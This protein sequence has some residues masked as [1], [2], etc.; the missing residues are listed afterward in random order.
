[1]PY[2][3]SISLEETMAKAND[4]VG[5]PILT[6]DHEIYSPPLPLAVRWFGRVGRRYGIWCEMLCMQWEKGGEASVIPL[7]LSPFQATG[8]IYELLMR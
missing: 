3:L 7:A 5:F 2:G 4:A 8:L 1:M 6:G